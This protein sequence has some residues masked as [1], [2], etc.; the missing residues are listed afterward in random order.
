MRILIL[1][2]S[3]SV[4]L[5]G[6]GARAH[7]PF[8]A[9]FDRSK[10]VAVTGT[11]ES[12]EWAN[13]HASIQVKGSAMR[14]RGAEGEW[15]IE[16]GAPDEL[17]R[18]GWSQETLKPGDK[19]TVQGWRARDGSMKVNARAIRTA[20]GKNMMAASSADQRNRG[21]LASRDPQGAAADSAGTSGQ[22][23][24]T[25]TVLPM[26]GLVGLLSLAAAV[27]LYVMRR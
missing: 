10:P 22:L 19:V 7:H 25:A 9:E 16:L 12:F 8:D 17:T 4:M 18:A 2:T 27:G 15:T 24:G 23:P 21:E 11:V 5:V 6:S 26:T 1:L 20:A 13:P 14:Q 3:L